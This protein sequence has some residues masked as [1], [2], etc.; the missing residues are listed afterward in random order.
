MTTTTTGTC[1]FTLTP[2]A[3][4]SNQKN[5][6]CHHCWPQLHLDTSAPRCSSLSARGLSRYVHKSYE[7]L[8]KYWLR[9]QYISNEEWSMICQINPRWHTHPYPT[10]SKIAVIQKH[11]HHVLITKR[12]C[13]G[14][15]AK[16]R[17]LWRQKY[18]LSSM[19]VLYSQGI[20]R[21][22]ILSD[23]ICILLDINFI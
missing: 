3:P 2:T 14:H 8:F 17:V 11:Q 15:S 7:V 21:D 5:N 16:I 1:Q 22:D 13:H 10:L 9:I 19:Q 23:N 18:C 6:C 20:F 4:A 12:Y